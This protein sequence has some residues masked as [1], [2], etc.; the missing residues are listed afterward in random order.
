MRALFNL[1]QIVATPGAL[2]ELERLGIDPV[3][4]LERHMTGDWGDMDDEDKEQNDIAVKLGDRRIF[5]AYVYEG[6]EWWVITEYD[7]S[8]TTILLPSEY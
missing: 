4:L 1:G 8:I 2:D 6:V 7:Y 5:S 3:T